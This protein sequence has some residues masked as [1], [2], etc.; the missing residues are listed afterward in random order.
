[1]VTKTL[2]KSLELLEY[3][4]RW[5][6]PIGVVDLAR[7]LGQAK[8]NVFRLLVTLESH[9]F[10]RQRE[11]ARYEPTLKLWELGCL[12][13]SRT[14]LTQVANPVLEQL[15]MDVG[16]SSQ[17]AVLDRDESIFIDKRNGPQPITG[18]TRIGTRAPA[19]C[20]ATGKVELAMQTHHA[21]Q[22]FAEELQAHTAA[23]LSTRKALADELKAIRKAGFAVNRGEWFEDVWGVAAAIHDHTGIVCASIGIWGPR[24][25]VFPAVE[26]IAP[27]VIE[28][29]S[30]IS[31]ALGCPA[32]ILK[33]TTRSPA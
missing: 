17:L 7:A 31:R 27:K 26:A 33:T 25:R 20:C 11:D 18:F 10:V 3:L 14:S 29:A 8:S 4:A 2:D 30:T 15:A 32:E 12:I 16:E 28:A 5:G 9:D 21:L 13:V 6:Q 1:M 22:G 24:Q 19:Y 23:T